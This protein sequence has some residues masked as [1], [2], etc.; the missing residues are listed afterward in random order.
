[1]RL[2]SRFLVDASLTLILEPL[3][4]SVSALSCS[5]PAIICTSPSFPMATRVKRFSSWILGNTIYDRC[6][7]SRWIL[8]TLTFVSLDTPVF[9]LS[10]TSTYA[11]GATSPPEPKIIN[12]S[13]PPATTSHLPST[14]RGASQSISDVGSNFESQEV[15]KLGLLS[16]WAQKLKVRKAGKLGSSNFCRR[17][18]GRNLESQLSYFR[19]FIFGTQNDNP[20]NFPPSGLLECPALL[21]R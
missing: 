10:Y 5:P 12:T 21:L 11:S 20:T 4:R 8:D 9:F 18:A 2:E 15:R 19:T 6:N 7:V 3:T 13:S 16:F 14:S 17:K 1:M